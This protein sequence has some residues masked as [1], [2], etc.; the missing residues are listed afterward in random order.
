MKTVIFMKV[1]FQKD[2]LMVVASILEKIP[3]TME[4]SRR[5]KS[6]ALAKRFL[7]MVLSF[8]DN[9]LKILNMVKESINGLMEATIL[10]IYKMIIL[11]EWEYMLLLNLIRYNKIDFCYS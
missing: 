8:R 1:I 5:E 2:N 7:K 9:F 10:V 3:F 6:M 11:K 4:N